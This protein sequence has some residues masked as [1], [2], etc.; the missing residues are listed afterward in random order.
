MD[1]TLNHLLDYHNAVNGDVEFALIQLVDDRD[2]IWR[3]I[4]SEEDMVTNPIRREWAQEGQIMASQCAAQQMRRMAT[5][6]IMDMPRARYAR[7]ALS[8]YVWEEQ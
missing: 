5:W 6:E 7:R 8:Q 4:L 1:A 3:D 2:T